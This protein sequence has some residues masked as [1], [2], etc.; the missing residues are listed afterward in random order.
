MTGNDPLAAAV[1]VIERWGRGHPALTHLSEVE[2]FDWPTTVIQGGGG[3]E[4]HVD[5]LKLGYL[6]YLGYA[7]GRLG[8]AEDVR[9]ELL[10]KAYQT[11]R[12]PRVFPVGY[13][14][15]WGG[16]SS[17]S[18]LHKMADSI[19]TFCRNGR[20]R[21][22]DMDIAVSEWEADLEW[23]RTTYYEGRYQF[24]WPSVKVW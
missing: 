4:L 15:E 17:S 6:R 5:A 24:E 14:K 22:H 18:R 1:D 13:R 7:V 10:S 23:L 20:R 3:S 9:H 12:L 16:P 11:R 21:P 8:K 19:A 2:A